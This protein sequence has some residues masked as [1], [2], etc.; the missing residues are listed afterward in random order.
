MNQVKNPFSSLVKTAGVS[1]TDFFVLWFITLIGA[2]LR[3]TLLDFQSL[4][5]DELTFA[6][7]A[8]AKNIFEA[9]SFCAQTRDPPG[10]DLLLFFLGKFFE[11]TDSILRFPSAIAGTLAIPVA[12]LFAKEA[13]SIR[14]GLLLACLVSFLLPFVT[15]SQEVR[16]YSLLLLF[17]LS[18]GF[19]W[20][21]AYFPEQDSAGSSLPQ[22]RW[23]ILYRCLALLGIYFH[24][25]MIIVVG[26]QILSSLILCRRD[27]A[28]TQATLRSASIFALA[29]LPLLPL[30]LNYWEA[31]DGWP[32]TAEQGLLVGY[33][34]WLFNGKLALAYLG[35]ASMALALVLAHMPKFSIERKQRIAITAIAFWTLSLVFF[36]WAFSA[37]IKPIQ[38]ERYFL[39]VAAFALTVVIFPICHF[40][41]KKYFLPI[42]FLF[43]FAS[44]Y[45]LIFTAQFY[46]KVSKQQV[47]ELVMQVA[48]ET[49][50]NSKTM[51]ASAPPA[52]ILRLYLDRFIPQHEDVEKLVTPKDLSALSQKI[53]DTRS[54]YL[55]YI[56]FNDIGF[57]S[58]PV[59][60]L[61]DF[62]FDH[63]INRHGANAYL[64]KI[65]DRAPPAT[66]DQ[67]KEPK[68]K[69]K[70]NSPVKKKI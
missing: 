31:Y 24:Y 1:N 68:K 37:L 39:L 13:I 52:S 62:E 25:L 35:I 20:M 30:L 59:L 66:L 58:I 19:A 14:A 27:R 42:I 26:A 29:M 36:I 21:K 16:S 47:R 3:F 6:R 50:L 12:F 34:A 49:P 11:P 2:I 38:Y 8:V 40:L 41:P 46:S 63:E 32:K 64:F 44:L 22:R 7:A 48:S 65:R 15:Y 10:L 17:S 5:Y 55:W 33:M 67:A 9:L 28:Q 18:A 4:W 45:D 51:L 53:Q 23:H 43:G 57:P 61:K 70:K 56:N 60:L 69:S 54:N